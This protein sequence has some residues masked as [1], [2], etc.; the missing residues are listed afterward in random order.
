M[1]LTSS[2]SGITPTVTIS[3]SSNG[4]QP[5]VSTTV[6]STVQSGSV[7]SF[8]ESSARGLQQ[9]CTNNVTSSTMCSN[10]KETYLPGT[11]TRDEVDAAVSVLSEKSLSMSSASNL[12][13]QPSQCNPVDTSQNQSLHISA[14]SNKVSRSTPYLTFVRDVSSSDNSSTPVGQRSSPMTVQI[15]DNADTFHGLPSEVKQLYSSFEENMTD[16]V[17]NEVIAPR[18]FRMFLHDCQISWSNHGIA[19]SSMFCR[20]CQKTIGFRVLI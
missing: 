9:E 17:I 12:S 19:L 14:E 15:E 13:S 10:P 18:V 2:S 6:T 1:T 3:T 4:V 5:L 16:V 8:Q 7:V 11:L 20:C